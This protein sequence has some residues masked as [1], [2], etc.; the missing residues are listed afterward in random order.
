VTIVGWGGGNNVERRTFYI[1]HGGPAIPRLTQA[2]FERWLEN[3]PANIRELA[4]RNALV[5]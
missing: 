2:L 1:D 4:R 5:P 3:V